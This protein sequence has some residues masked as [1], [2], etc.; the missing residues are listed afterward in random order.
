MGCVILRQ[1]VRQQSPFFPHSVVQNSPGIGG[2]DVGGDGLDAVLHDPVQSGPEGIG[3]IAIQT[4]DEAAVDHDAPAV[5]G[6][7]CRLIFAGPVLSLVD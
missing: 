3:R 2:Q 1:I 5:D 7:D 4:K 6:A